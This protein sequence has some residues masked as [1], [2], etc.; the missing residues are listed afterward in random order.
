MSKNIKQ[1]V[2]IGFFTAFICIGAYIRI[3]MIPVP[4]TMQSFF[5]MLAA[6]ILGPKCG[7]LTVFLYILL[8]I[9]GLPL[10]SGGGGIQYIIQPTFGFIIGFLITSF[11]AGLLCKKN[12]MSIIKIFL[13]LIISIIPL[14][15]TGGIYFYFVT[16]NILAADVKLFTVIYSCCLIFIPGD[17][18][19]CALCAIFAKKLHRLT[20]VAIF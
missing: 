3:P 7:V 20:G 15:L 16:K 2:L 18:L 13:C 4:I 10:F 12:N 8:G 5:V 9:C 1:S 17:I 14:Y 19:K 6:M 11:C